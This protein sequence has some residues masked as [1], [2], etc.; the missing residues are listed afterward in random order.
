MNRLLLVILVATAIMVLMTY[1]FGKLFR[2]I[3]WVK[4]IPGA[5]II[6]ISIYLFF[7]SRQPSQGF[8]NLG[9]FIMVL[10]F[11]PAGVS[12][13]IAAFIMDYI[14]YKKYNT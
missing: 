13:I 14:M 5:M 1:V 3:R 4:Y 8:E 12:A 6:A 7:M 11:F 2:H 10:I 9:Q